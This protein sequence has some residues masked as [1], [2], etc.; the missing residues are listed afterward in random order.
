MTPEG[1]PSQFQ[2]KYRSPMSLTRQSALRSPLLIEPD[3]GCGLFT[4][5]CSVRTAVSTASPSRTRKLPSSTIYSI[6]EEQRTSTNPSMARQLP[7]PP[8][9]E[10]HAFSKH[11]LLVGTATC[12]P[13]SRQKTWR[14]RAGR[15]GV[16]PPLRHLSKTLRGHQRDPQH[17]RRERVH[18]GSTAARSGARKIRRP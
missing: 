11:N 16:K 1:H 13:Q 3:N 10:K 2:V 4:R 17:R 8:P 9:G 18:R 14:K 6:E 7:L 5:L 12:T 15:G